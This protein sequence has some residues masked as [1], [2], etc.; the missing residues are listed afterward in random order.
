[1]RKLEAETKGKEARITVLE[2]DLEA[3]AAALEAAKAAAVVA[4]AEHQQALAVVEA[5]LEERVRP[6]CLPAC[7][8]CP[9]RLVQPDGV[10]CSRSLC[11]LPRPGGGAKR[12]HRGG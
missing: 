2:A 8:G 5:S 1:M 6:A 7:S 10:V 9:R 11:A 12:E 3:S 4:A